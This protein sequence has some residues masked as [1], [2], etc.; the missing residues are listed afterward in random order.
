MNRWIRF[1]LRRLAY[2]L[3]TLFLITTFTFFLMNALPG[4]PY[5]NQAQLTQVQLDVL[6]AK[7][8]FDKPVF[9]QYINYLRNILHGDFGISLQF[10]DQKVTTLLGNRIGYSVQLGLQAVVFGTVTGIVLGLSLIHI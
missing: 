9:V 10:S 5:N 7:Y 6:N 8:G 1:I 3:L 4:T 2:M